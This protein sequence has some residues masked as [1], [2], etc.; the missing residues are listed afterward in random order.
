MEVKQ[1]ISAGKLTGTYMSSWNNELQLT[2]EGGHEVT[3]K[4]D[5]GVLRVLS[6]RLNER[7]ESIDKERDEQRQAEIEEAVKADLLEKAAEVLEDSD[8]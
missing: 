3:V 6:V 2:V 5:E 8:A 4:L 1:V 7:I